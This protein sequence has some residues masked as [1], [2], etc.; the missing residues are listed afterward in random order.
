MVKSGAIP[1]AGT[2]KC[3][4]TKY[5]LEIYYVMKYIYIYICTYI[6][7]GKLIMYTME[8]ELSIS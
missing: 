6:T 8:M 3:L 7:Y 4:A 1:L 2:M 5:G